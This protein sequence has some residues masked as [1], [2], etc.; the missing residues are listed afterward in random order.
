M[1]KKK[2]ILLTQR[3]LESRRG[4]ASSSTSP[5]YLGSILGVLTK[6]L[7]LGASE[8]SIEQLSSE[9]SLELMSSQGIPSLF[10]FCFV[11]DAAKLS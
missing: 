9:V 4:K 2:T 8:V 10:R 7:G 3:Q 1:R 11:Q 5:G 6:P